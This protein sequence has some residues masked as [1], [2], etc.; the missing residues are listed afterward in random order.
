MGNT[1]AQ[2][3]PASTGV[4]LRS[5]PRFVS[6]FHPTRPH[7]VDV[8]CLIASLHRVQLPPTR[9]CLRL[10]PQGTCTPNDSS[11]PSA[12]R[13][14]QLR[15]LC[16]FDLTQ[17]QEAV[18][19]SYVYTRFLR[20]LLKHADQ[21]EAIFDQLVEQLRQQL[22]G[23]G[24]ILALDG[25]AIPTAA[26]PRKKDEQDVQPDGRRDL[27]ADHGKKTYKGQRADGSLWEK[28]ASRFGY[29]LHLIVCGWACR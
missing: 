26:R 29:N 21:V 15:W 19:S 27:D 3:G 2:T 6:G 5:V 22:P 25:K 7:G 9:G 18:P 24:H 10:A 11:M 17:G 1:L 28:V 4:H 23:F 12:P 14:G 20:L 16:G 8:G 13:N